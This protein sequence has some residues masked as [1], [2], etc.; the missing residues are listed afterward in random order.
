MHGEPAAAS[1]RLQGGCRCD[2]I[3]RLAEYSTTPFPLRVTPAA[4]RSVAAYVPWSV[5]KM[6]ASL[7]TLVTGGQIEAQGGCHP[8]K[9]SHAIL[10]VPVLGP[11]GVLTVLP[12]FSVS[13][14]LE[15]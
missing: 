12:S 6:K 14:S 15:P 9:A 10:G 1:R 7:G 3:L 2:V 11:S 13:S 8:T 5:N 4:A